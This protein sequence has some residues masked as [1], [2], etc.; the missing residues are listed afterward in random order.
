MGKNEKI[1]S[2]L[3]NEYLNDYIEILGICVGITEYYPQQADSQIR[4]ALTHLSRAAYFDDKA[5]IDIEVERAK[6]HIERA[7]RDCLKLAI[8]RKK[9]HISDHIKSVH[10]AK[11][12][13]SE[14]IMLKRLQV[15][16]DQKVAFIN[17]TKGL[18][19]TSELEH[20]LTQLVNLENDII[21]F[22]KIAFQPSKAVYIASIVIKYVKKIMAV[23]GMAVMV[24][25]ISRG[26]VP[27]LFS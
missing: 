27:S 21:Q 7:K 3:L 15:S 23:F 2:I 14:D 13:L 19:V 16:K 9:E 5:K 12:G 22:D 8:I 18:N 11:G 1:I 20:V 25:W 4:N 17:E 24:Y 6:G 10:Y 26:V